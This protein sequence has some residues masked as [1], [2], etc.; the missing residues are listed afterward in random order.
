MRILLDGLD[1]MDNLTK[2]YDCL[3]VDHL[4]EKYY[5]STAYTIEFVLGVIGN[6]VVMFGYIFCMKNWSSGSIYLFNLCISDYLFLWTLPLL[7]SSYSHE[8]WKFGD[9]LCK[10]NR[11][12]LH[13]NLYTS[14]LFLAFISIDRYMLIKYPFREHILQKKTS[15]VLISI[16]IWIFVSIEIIPI[17]TFIK[18]SKVGN[19]TIC[20]NF[21]SSGDASWSLVYSLCLTFTG[22]IVPLCVI[23]IF[24]LKIVYFLKNRNNRITTAISLDKPLTLVVL[25]AIMFS[26][27]FTPYHIMRNVRI[28][29]RSESWQLS[30]CSMVVVNT[31]YII[32]RPL[33]FSSSVIN[34]VFYFLMGDHFRELLTTKVQSLYKRVK[35]YCTNFK[36]S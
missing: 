35:C 31:V 2:Q 9:T 27:L 16:G 14:I 23:W 10:S 4:L 7:V 21:G 26:V 13:E 32:T 5:L 15:A 29:S 20:Q 34:P 25:A 30:Y 22:F 11:Y 36:G 24:Y 18:E 3:D 33:A 19:S 8:Q 28:A 6:S 17:L 1:W 12:F